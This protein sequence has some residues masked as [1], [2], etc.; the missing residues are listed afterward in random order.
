MISFLCAETIV[1]H[2]EAPIKCTEFCPEVN[3]VVSGSWDQT[4]KLWD[5]RTPSSAG[6]FSQP[7]KVY[8]LKHLR[9]FVQSD[10]FLPVF[11]SHDRDT[12]CGTL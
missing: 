12:A 8:I 7:D 3:V 1:G 5:P 9:E 2:H 11:I 4:V 6:S 10:W